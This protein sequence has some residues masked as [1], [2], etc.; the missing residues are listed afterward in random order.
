MLFRERIS[1]S[2][3]NHTEH[4]EYARHSVTMTKQAGGIY[5]REGSTDSY[6]L[7]DHYYTSSWPSLPCQ[8]SVTTEVMPPI[9]VK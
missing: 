8:V 6:N 7:S 2:C 5:F 4:N 1:A 9:V 3:E